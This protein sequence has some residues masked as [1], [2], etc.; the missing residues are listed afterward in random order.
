MLDFLSR[1]GGGCCPNNKIRCRKKP[2]FQSQNKNLLH[3]LTTVNV[4]IGTFNQ[5]SHHLHPATHQQPHMIM[6]SILA[7]PLHHISGFIEQLTN[8]I[9]NAS[10][11]SLHTTHL[12]EPPHH[13]S[14][15]IE[16]LTKANQAASGRASTTTYQ[17]SSGRASSLHIRLH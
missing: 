17:A 1:T 5:K 12:A 15:F 3:A 13:I 7:G 14:G 6:T 11:R 16:Q 9:Q 4:Y 8:A 2:T 10:G